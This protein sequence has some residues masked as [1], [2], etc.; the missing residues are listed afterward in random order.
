MF[1]L[2]LQRWIRARKEGVSCI[3]LFHFASIHL[4]REYSIA[5]G[6]DDVLDSRRRRFDIC[7]Q[8]SL[9]LKPK[10]S[11]GNYEE[12][13]HLS[14]GGRQGDYDLIHPLLVTEVTA[15]QVLGFERGA[16]APSS[17]APPEAVKTRSSRV[18]L[19]GIIRLIGEEGIVKGTR[20]FL[21]LFFCGP[22]TL[23]KLE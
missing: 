16:V 9:G 13:S 20:H 15:R 23:A 11:S 1:F 2:A 6:T 12:M 8:I 18:G 14:G 10:T 5:S 4:S 22:K 3:H 21:N 7:G 19:G 17:G